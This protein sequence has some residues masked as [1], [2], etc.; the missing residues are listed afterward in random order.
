MSRL[1]AAARA[2]GATDAFALHRVAEGQLV[3]LDGIGRGSGWAGNIA[4]D[5]DAE[6]W[7]DSNANYPCRHSG[8]LRRLFGP[9]WS[10]EAVQVPVGEFVV[11]FSGPGVSANDDDTL[12]DAAADIAWS[13]GEIPTEKRLADELE[14]SQAALAIASIDGD[15]LQAVTRAL[16]SEAAEL[17]GC[18][19]S[20][21]LLSG[22]PETLVFGDGSWRPEASDEA[23]RLA[24][25][26][27]VG[28]ASDLVLD[29]EV[30]SSPEAVRPL[31]YD[32]GLIAR[33]AI[34]MRSDTK[35]IGWLICAHTIE[36]PR[37]FTSLCQR[38]A[39]TIGD[40]GTRVLDR[41]LGLAG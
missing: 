11:V 38:V 9:F 20:V 2:V 14:V 37:G 33:C 30:A 40:Q 31:S 32:D 19:F 8:E 36:Q 39:E 10:E 23:L 27:L 35:D 25:K 1:E 17:L 5:P 26:Q 6:P 4:I 12:V 3:N 22:P 29:Q 18:Q 7:L 13:V 21:V 41:R 34:P 24:I 16:A 15:D 28:Q